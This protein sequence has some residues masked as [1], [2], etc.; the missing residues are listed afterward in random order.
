VPLRD[1]PAAQPAPT[2]TAVIRGRVIAADNRIPIRRAIVSLTT[3]APAR[4]ARQTIFT[5]ARGR[6][7]FRG[8]AAGEYV[9]VAAP[10]QYQGQ[11]VA[12]V[13]PPGGPPRISLAEGQIVDGHDLTLPRGGAIVGRLVDADGDPLSGVLVSAQR[14]GDAS[15]SY[16]AIPSDEHGRYRLYR[17]APGDYTVLARPG[18]NTDPI[19]DSSA[20][21]YVDTYHPSVPS[22]A[23][24]APVRV[25][26]GEESAAG[27]LVLIRA[28]LLKIAGMVLDSRGSPATPS[29]TIFLS[30]EGTTHGI[31]LFPGGR[32]SFRAQPPGTYTLIARLA[33]HFTAPPSEY[34]TLT[35]TLVDSD[36]D[37]LVIAMK[38]TVS[39]RGRVVFDGDN[40]P[41][42]SGNT[43]N[44]RSMGKSGRVIDQTPVAG[45]VVGA[46]LSFTLGGLVDEVLIRPFDIPE[47]WMLKSVHLG[48]RDISDVPTEFRDSDTGRLQVILSRRSSL[49][50]GTVTDDRG[51]PAEEA[52]V[53]LFA[54][55]RAYWFRNATRF[56]IA[57]L[58]GNGSFVFSGI[59]GGRYRVIALRQIDLKLAAAK[60]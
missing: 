34:A 32:F 9:L 19:G 56:R 48:D 38:P 51:R 13:S 6:Y 3:V 22:R 53:L 21:G 59:P 4:A 16:H 10:N 8:L 27:D 7:E 39:L 15:V 40:A 47:G 60:R 18:A 57:H 43:L 5:D 50:R 41:T 20:I 14:V 35:V 28:R 1:T 52:Q 26:G 11:F 54:E 31:A 36:A 25:R 55:D 29:T 44:I 58:R 46:D 49:I 12:P 24:A 45:A 17:L 33:E 42:L 30:H 37:D 23:E 2:G